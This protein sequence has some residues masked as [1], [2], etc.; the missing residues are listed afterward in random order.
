MSKGIV[1][2]LTGTLMLP[3]ILS[4]SG[5]LQ[6]VR[7]PPVRLMFYNVENLF[8]TFDDTLKDDDEFL[9]GGLRGWNIT[10]T[11]GR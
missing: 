6:D 7:T 4:F 3:L 8:D 5:H 9:P 2:R 1:I 11:T 10:G